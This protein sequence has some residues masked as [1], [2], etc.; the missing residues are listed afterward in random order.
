MR[1]FKRRKRDL[2]Q[3]DYDPVR[4]WVEAPKIYSGLPLK[5]GEYT[6]IVDPHTGIGI[7]VV[8]RIGNVTRY[9]AYIDGRSLNQGFVRISPQELKQRKK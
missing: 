6:V 8:A 5:N 2:F 4:E 9:S 3:D 7:Y 1:R